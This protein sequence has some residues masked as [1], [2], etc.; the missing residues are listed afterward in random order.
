MVLAGKQ[1]CE[2]SIFQVR[3]ER[4]KQLA[5]PFGDDGGIRTRGLLTENQA[6]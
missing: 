4:F 5:T 3:A 6:A 1:N 2:F